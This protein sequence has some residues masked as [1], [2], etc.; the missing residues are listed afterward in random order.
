VLWIR[1]RRGCQFEGFLGGFVIDRC[2]VPRPIPSSR[3]IS[4]HERPSLRSADTCSAS[5]ST[6]GLPRAPPCFFTRSNP[7]MTRSRIN[8]RSRSVQKFDLVNRSRDR[9]VPNRSSEIWRTQSSNIVVVQIADDVCAGVLVPLGRRCGWIRHPFRAQMDWSPSF[10]ECRDLASAPLVAQR[11]SECRRGR[12]Y[13]RMLQNRAK[14][15]EFSLPR[16]PHGF[17]EPNRNLIR[18]TLERIAEKYFSQK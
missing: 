13:A 3:A 7:M 6:R 14:G 10:I 1:G 15:L 16:I 18:S 4:V 17:F 11:L 12:R 9:D 2:A 5:T 8:D